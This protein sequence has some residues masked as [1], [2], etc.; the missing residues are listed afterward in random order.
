MDTV[1]E[2][3]EGDYVRAMKLYSKITRKVVVIYALVAAVLVLL[4]LFG[5]PVLKGAAIGGLKSR[6]SI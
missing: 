1:Y 5:S 4:A 2:I 3:T 6:D